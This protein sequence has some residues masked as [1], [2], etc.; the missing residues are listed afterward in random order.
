MIGLAAYTLLGRARRAALA[1]L[2]LVHPELDASAHRALAR[3]NFRSLGRN[4]TDTLALLDPKEDPARS[5][6][7]SASSEHVLADALAHR[8]G[9]IYVTC[10]LGPWE[11]MAALLAERGFPI[12]TVARESYDPRFHALIYERLRARRNV[13]VIYRGTP[14][15][16]V[17]IVRALRRGRV[18]GLLMD[19]PGR[20]ATQSVT[21]LGLP[22][23]VPIGAARLALRLRSPVVVGTPAPNSAGLEIRIAK[24]ETEDLASGERGEAVLSQ[25]IADALSERIRL[26]PTHWPWMHPTFGG[27][28]GHRAG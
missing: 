16:P 9:V 27:A 8:R 6:S 12:T 14:S 4:L 20:I 24:L 26:L 17:A 15:A 23:R 2:A 22:S 18:L 10:H 28:S 5:L 25:R 19:M 3:A 21:W 11:R 7:V 1:N 13:Q